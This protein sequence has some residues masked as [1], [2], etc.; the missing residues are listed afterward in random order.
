MGSEFS[1]DITSLGQT[2]L[3]Y[4]QTRWDRVKRTDRSDGPALRPRRFL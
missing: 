3:G 4:R 2:Y 1:M